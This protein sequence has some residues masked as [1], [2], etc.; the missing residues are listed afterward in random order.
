MSL[1]LIVDGKF[2]ESVVATLP[3]LTKQYPKYVSIIGMPKP[4]SIIDSYLEEFELDIFLL[5]NQITMQDYCEHEGS[6]GINAKFEILH[7]QCTTDNIVFRVVAT[8]DSDS[9]INDYQA[10]TKTGIISHIPIT[11]NSGIINN[12][13]SKELIEQL[14]LLSNPSTNSKSKS[15]FSWFHGTKAY[16]EKELAREYAMNMFEKEILNFANNANKKQIVKA[17]CKI[18]YSKCTKSIIVFETTFTHYSEN[19]LNSLFKNNST[20]RCA[21]HIKSG[22]IIPD[23]E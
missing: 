20:I 10:D 23:I 16:N 18:I 13:F 12:K 15:I 7:E 19:I 14:P 1:G 4:Y 17:K 5:V 22:Q 11:S 3:K 9:S 21:V 6:L 8:S 2:R